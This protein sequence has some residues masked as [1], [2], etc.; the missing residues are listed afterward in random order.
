MISQVA[1]VSYTFEFRGVKY[2]VRG[3]TPES[4]RLILRNLSEMSLQNHETCFPLLVA[5]FVLISLVDRSKI[6]TRKKTGKIQK[7]QK[8]WRPR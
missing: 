2:R 3:L 8:H 7:G 1:S 4:L 6:R 5:V